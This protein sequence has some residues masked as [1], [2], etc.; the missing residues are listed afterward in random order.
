MADNFCMKC[1][2]YLINDGK[3]ACWLGIS[4][5]IKN[6]QWIRDN[7]DSY[8]IQNPHHGNR[9]LTPAEKQSLAYKKRLVS[10][11]WLPQWK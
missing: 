1:D 11:N 2:T 3:C 6:N 8:P 9:R 10:I 5:V 4:Q 7:D